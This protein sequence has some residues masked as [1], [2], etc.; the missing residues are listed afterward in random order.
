MLRFVKGADG[1]V[2]ADTAQKADGRGAY[3]CGEVACLN[4]LIGKKLLNKVFSCKVDE[5][6]YLA[7]AEGKFGGK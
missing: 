3:V 1:V 2:F 6:I 4:K 5:G 7:V